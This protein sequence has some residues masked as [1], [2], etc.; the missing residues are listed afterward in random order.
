MKSSNKSLILM[1]F[2]MVM[3]IPSVCLIS[4]SVVNRDV[5]WCTFGIFALIA[6]GYFIA[7]HHE[8]YVLE[9]KTSENVVM[10]R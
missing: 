2:W 6:S 5:V 7:V 4:S 9:M 8:E 10:E 1:G 3:I